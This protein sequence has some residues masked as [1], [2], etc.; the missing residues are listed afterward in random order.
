M[1]ATGS[2]FQASPLHHKGS[3]VAARAEQRERRVQRVV[4]RGYQ[5]EL[6]C[7]T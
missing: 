3:Q 5:G 4:S 1:A 7:R 2:R 6:W